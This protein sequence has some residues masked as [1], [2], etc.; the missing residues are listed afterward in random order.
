ML[1][2]RGS[3]GGQGGPLL[4]A[5]PVLLVDDDEAEPAERDRLL[6]QVKERGFTDAY[7]V[8]N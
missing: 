3:P 5:E 2:R 4:D 7:F 6:A 1:P 8:R